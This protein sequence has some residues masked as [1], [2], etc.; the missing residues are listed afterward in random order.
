MPPLSRHR[1]QWHYISAYSPWTD[2]L[3]TRLASRET[4]VKAE[5]LGL[6]VVV[7]EIVAAARAFGGAE[8]APRRCTAKQAK[9]H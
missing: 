5:R 7:D 3:G 8:D 6:D 2:S 9:P 4:A 1:L